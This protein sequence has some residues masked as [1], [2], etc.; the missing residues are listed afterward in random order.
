MPSGRLRYRVGFYQ[1][2]ANSPD[3]PDYGYPDGDYPDTPTLVRWANIE[4]KLGGEAVLA[5]RLTGKNYVNITIR[6]SADTVHIDTD[7]KAKDEDTGE[8]FNIRSIIDPYKGTARN[9]H[10]IEMLCEKGVA[11]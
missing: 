5:A 1:R 6:Q 10:W 2:G 4:P 9:G 7:W 11:I 3:V 8:E